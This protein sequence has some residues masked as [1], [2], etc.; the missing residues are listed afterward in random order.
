MYMFWYVDFMGSL[1]YMTLVLPFGLYFSET[2][3]AKEF[4]WRV[5]SAFKNE[6]ITLS[7]ISIIIFPAYAFMNYAYIPLTANTCAWDISNTEMYMD[8]FIPAD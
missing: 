3:E 6:V 5:C 2:D 4:K 1:I 8:P 7:L